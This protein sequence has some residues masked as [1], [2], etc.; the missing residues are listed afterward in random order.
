MVTGAVATGADTG[1]AGGVNK[2]ASAEA[3]SP[4]G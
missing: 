3:V 1:N 2:E 4:P